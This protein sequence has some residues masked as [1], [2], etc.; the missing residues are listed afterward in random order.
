MTKT[1]PLIASMIGKAKPSSQY[2]F[3]LS[4]SLS[5]HTISAWSVSVMLAD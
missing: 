4:Q 3:G 1:T 2:S 5:L